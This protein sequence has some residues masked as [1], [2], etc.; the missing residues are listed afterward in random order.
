M[1]QID[2][3]FGR[4]GQLA[5][6]LEGF[7]PRR[8]Q[9]QMAA[10]VAEALAE[11]STLIVEA[12]TGTGKTFAYLVPALLS[13]KRVFVSTG[14]R[15]LQDQLFNKDVPLVAAALGRPAR[16]AL[17]KGRA[18]Y[19]CLYRLDRA[20]AQGSFDALAP[21]R[22]AALATLQRWAA[23]TRRGDLAEVPGLNDTDPLWA[24]VTSTRD[25]CLGQ[26]CPDFSRCHLVAARREAQ[27]A[28]IVVVNHH[29]LFA[30]LAL[31]EDGFGDLLG[32]ADAIILDEAHQLPDLATRFFG[33]QLASRQIENLLADSR[34]ALAAAGVGSTTLQASLKEVEAALNATLA[35]VPQ[36]AGRLAWD[37]SGA[38]L[39]SFVLALLASLRA[40]TTALGDASRDAAVAQCAERAE[41]FAAALEQITEAGGEEGARTVEASGRGFTLTLLPFDIAERFQAIVAQ[42]RMAWIFTSAT[43]TVGDDFSHFSDR[44]GLSDAPSLRIPSPFDYE[45]QA[46]LYLPENIPAPSAP[47]YLDAVLGVAERLIEAAH[48]GAFVLFTSHRAL[49][50]AAAVARAT[51]SVLAELPL[52]VQGESPRERLLQQFREH[53]DAV[54]FGT[55]SFWEGVDV[56]GEA[57]RLVIIEKL[58]FAAPED[59]LVKARIAHLESIGANP[60]RDYQLPEAVLALKQGFGRLIRSESDRGVIAICDPRLSTRSYGRTFIASLPVIPITR[61]LSEA[62]RFLRRA[63]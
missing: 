15:T 24:Q 49:T 52:L 20:S 3:I 36:R 28:D 37:Q 18:N 56:K 16:I 50:R 14:T 9:L 58:P 6:A 33:V 47:A 11:S 51:W 42:R 31:K 44:M 29:L 17:L 60:F 40:V 59:P 19:L 45:S 23:V 41:R 25:N 5:R 34:A 46:L 10:R 12:G 2:D 8:S 26:R 57:L 54:L 22:S 53:G 13:G 30:D 38:D 4:G 61:D 7:H 62:R 32:T 35:V 1:E 48:G 21:P 63:H 27:E 43:L 55:S 39:E